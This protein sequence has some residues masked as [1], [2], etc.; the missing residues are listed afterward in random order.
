MSP[1]EHFLVTVPDVFFLSSFFGH[2][3]NLGIWEA[4]KDSILQKE[5]KEGLVFG[6]RLDGPSDRDV[7]V[8][9]MRP[10]K[11][12]KRMKKAIRETDQ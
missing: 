8:L 6:V 10:S 3:E 2:A 12:E 4:V 5:R 11:D 1:L 7:I 9:Q